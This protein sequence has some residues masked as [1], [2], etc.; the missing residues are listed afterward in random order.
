MATGERCSGCGAGT[1]EPGLCERCVWR[2]TQKRQITAGH[3]VEGSEDDMIR[4]V[5]GWCPECGG[6]GMVMRFAPEDC[7]NLGIHVFLDRFLHQ[8]QP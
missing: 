2:V 1:T 6:S 8:V 5:Q 4:T 7:P 3:T